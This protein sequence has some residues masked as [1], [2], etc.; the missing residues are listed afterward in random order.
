MSNLW[1]VPLCFAY[2]Q[3]QILGLIALSCLGTV[4]NL[5][6]MPLCFPLYPVPNL[7]VSRFVLFTH[8][9]KFVSYIAVFSFI[10]SAKF[11]GQ[12][13]CLVYAVR[14]ISELC[15]CV[16][17]YSQCQIWG[18]VALSCLRKVSNLWLISL[19]FH[20]Y[21]VPNFGV[22]RFALWHTVPN[23]WVISIWPLQQVTTPIQITS[24]L[25]VL[26][27]FLETP[28]RRSWFR[29]KHVDD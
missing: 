3:C 24:L 11:W 2:T 17:I 5:W 13:F 15:R 26:L 16:F 14:H 22:N 23:L 20:L 12:S 27:V 1:V 6:V 8:N 29:P 21:L 7:G 18:L 10:T 19:C 4:S 28:W 9:V 25:Y